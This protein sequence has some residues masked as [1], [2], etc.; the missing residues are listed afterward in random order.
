MHHLALTRVRTPTHMHTHA[1]THAAGCG[2]FGLFSSEKR[3]RQGRLREHEHKEKN[4]RERFYNMTD[5]RP[6]E[7][8]K[9]S[10]ENKG[11]RMETNCSV[12]ILKEGWI[13]HLYTNYNI[14]SCQ[15]QYSIQKVASVCDSYIELNPSVIAL[16]QE[17]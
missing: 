9:K 8:S 17:C 4:K 1:P 11:I 2:H 16:S 10:K 13:Q 3:R 7:L 12:L 15:R 5:G 14:Y 6:D